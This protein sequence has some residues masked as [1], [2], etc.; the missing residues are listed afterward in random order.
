M[1]KSVQSDE[2]ERH[3]YHLHIAKALDTL[4]RDLDIKATW[5]ANCLGISECLLSDYRTGKRAVPYYR[6]LLVDDLLGSNRMAK[7]GGDI[8]GFH[9]VPK[10]TENITSEDLERLFPQI[11]RE[12]GAAN[13]DV[14]AALLD[15]TLDNSERDIIHRH[16]AKLR[17][18]WQQVEERTASVPKLRREA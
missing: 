16:A 18:F 13:A 10:A 8:S 1:T 5:L 11:L 17:H 6:A 9:L 15:H 12:E 7:A 14:A 3:P 2:S 4:I